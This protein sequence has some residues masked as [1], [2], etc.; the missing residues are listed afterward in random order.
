MKPFQS[1]K[2]VLI[3][4]AILLIS[5]QVNAEDRETTVGDPNIECD[6]VLK[7]HDLSFAVSV[8]AVLH[9]M[10]QKRKILILDVRSPQEFGK[11]HIPG[12][13]NVPLYSIKTKPFLKTSQ[14]VLVNNGYI[15]AP[16]ENECIKLKEK[17]FDVSI[18]WGG[19]SAWKEKGLDFDGD[20]FAVKEL[21]RISSQDFFQEKESRENII[22]DVSSKVIP[23]SGQLFP[24]VRH[25]HDLTEK[26]FHNVLKEIDPGRFYTVLIFNENGQGYD[27]LE[28]AVKK[29]EIRNVFYLTGGI[30]EYKRF[31]KNFALSRTSKENRIKN[32]NKCIPCGQ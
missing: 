20:V 19:L 5:V 4:S 22:I 29:A 32:V 17:A 3:V 14:L 27:I 11:V 24:D 25:I 13:M 9:K 7:K 2:I 10:K 16:L 18:L 28:R 6:Q 31:L 12:S 26:S 8:E 1:L 30:N 21:N 23:E 15:Y